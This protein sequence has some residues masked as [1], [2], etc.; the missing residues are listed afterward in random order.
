MLCFCRAKNVSKWMTALMENVLVRSFILKTWQTDPWGG[1]RYRPTAGPKGIERSGETTRITLVRAVRRCQQSAQNSPAVIGRN[2]RVN[3]AGRVVQQTQNQPFFLSDQ[4]LKPNRSSRRATSPDTEPRRAQRGSARGGRGATAPSAGRGGALRESRAAGRGRSL[5]AA[6]T[7]GGLR[8]CAVQ[9]R[10]PHTPPR[11]DVTRPLAGHHGRIP[12]F[13]DGCAQR[14]GGLR[15]LRERR[16]GGGGDPGGRTARVPALARP[17]GR[18]G[19]PAPPWGV[20]GRPLSSPVPGPAAACRR[21]REDAAA[22]GAARL[23]PRRR[24]APVPIVPRRPPAPWAP[25]PAPASEPPARRLMAASEEGPGC[26]LPRGRSQSDPSILTEPAG[27]G[28]GEHAG[29]GPAHR[30]APGGASRSASALQPAEMQAD[31]R[32]CGHRRRRSPEPCARSSRPSAA[33]APRGAPHLGCPESVRVGAPSVEGSG[34]FAWHHH[35]DERQQ[36]RN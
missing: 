7:C 34:L 18:H 6:R 33:G 5:E 26:F 28:A 1:G 25:P 16:A 27:P 15:R 22:A 36:G 21:R 29:N 4:A 31:A 23:T 9:V 17:R 10:R 3:T 20:L 32:C 8:L 13:S 35:G 2:S 12:M 30:A 11:R 14:R 19:A 24:R